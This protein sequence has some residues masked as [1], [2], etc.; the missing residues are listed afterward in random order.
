MIRRGPICE[1]SADQRDILAILVSEGSTDRFT[2]K[3]L[4]ERERRGLITNATVYNQ[5]ERLSDDGLI[6]KR[7]AGDSGNRNKYRIARKG[8]KTLTAHYYWLDGCLEDG[9]PVC[10]GDAQ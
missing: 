2:I 7:S 3:Q 8:L 1:L 9:P 4:L 10:L 6:D 5:L